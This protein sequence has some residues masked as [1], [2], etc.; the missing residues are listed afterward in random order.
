MGDE[1]DWSEIEDDIVL[2]STGA[3]AVYENPRGDVVIRQQ[4]IDY[5]MGD[6]AVVVIPKKYALD[7]VRKIIDTADLK[8]GT[9]N[10]VKDEK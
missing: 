1:F 7:L 2:Q 3:I 8:F 4:G 5:Q 10:V 6:D 9:L